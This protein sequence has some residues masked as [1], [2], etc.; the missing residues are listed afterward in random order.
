MGWQEKGGGGARSIEE[1]RRRGHH[2]IHKQMWEA[3][4]SPP[5][6]FYTVN[7]SS[8]QNTAY[9]NHILIQKTVT[10]LRKQ[11]PNNAFRSSF[12]RKL[13]NWSQ[14]VS[15]TIVFTFALRRLR[16]RRRRRRRKIKGGGRE[17]KTEQKEDTELCPSQAFVECFT[18]YIYIY[19][20]YVVTVK[21][22][23]TFGE[24]AGYFFK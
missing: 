24:G 1:T 18:I 2:E 13:Y 23:Y 22:K 10:I 11:C 4:R 14:L 17:R 6:L 19:I 12:P 21:Y 20:Y 5:N 8:N 16:R 15:L 3:T 9:I 7:D